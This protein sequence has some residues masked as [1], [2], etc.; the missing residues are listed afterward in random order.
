[1]TDNVEAYELYLKGRY[2]INKFTPDGFLKAI[3]Y[4]NAAIVLEP[5]YAIAY[6][7]LTFC[8]ANLKDFNWLPREESLPQAIEAA[9]K[10][11]EL[12]DTISE[13]HMAVGRLLL[14]Q[15]WNVKK[16]L[17]E[18]KK[19]LSINPNSADAHIQIGFCLA[20]MEN[21][22]EASE[23]AKIAESLDPF[24]I[25]NLF[26]LA[27]IPFC[28]GD[29]E[30]VLAYGKR[31]IELEATMF[32]GYLWIGSAYLGLK[33]YDRAIEALEKMVQLNA[34]P[35][36]LSLLG[37][38]Y[39]LSGNKQQGKEIIRKMKEYDV[40]EDSGNAFLAN[41]YTSLGEFD[42][43][44]QYYDKAIDNREGQVIWTHYYIIRYLPE[45]MED[46]RT[47]AMFEKMNVIY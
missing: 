22:K 31:I 26:Y 2:H 1:D 43:A 32:S 19:A 20:H 7:E 24:S 27:V 37:L 42:A 17:V 46:P 29:Y 30:A 23:H 3:E 18:Y 38:G 16:A 13:S 41:V 5:S 11:L 47:K 9:Y 6:A 14:H 44:F 12:D 34:G 36:T 35:Y 25:L 8:Y 28:A 4:L 15:D 40:V 21:F 10:S 33:K 45:M 39:G